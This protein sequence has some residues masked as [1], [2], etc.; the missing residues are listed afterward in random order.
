MEKLFVNYHERFLA[1]K[2]LLILLVLIFAVIACNETT[3]PGKTGKLYVKFQ[4]DSS[5]WF[6]IYSIELQAMGAVEGDRLPKGNWSSNI[7]NGGKL[8]PPGGHEFF[9]LDIPNLHWSNCRLG[10][11]DSSGKR[12]LLHEQ[13][14]FQ[15]DWDYSITHWGGDTRT[16]NVTFNRNRHTGLITVN[17]WS[18]WTGID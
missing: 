8:I 3:T 11:I 15:P 4:N 18:D 13:T 1:M 12:L 14:G 7:L 17:S 16:I 6:T 5:S 2:K 9:N 10:I